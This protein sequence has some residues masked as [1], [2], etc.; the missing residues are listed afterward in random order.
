MSLSSCRWG[1]R[2]ARSGISDRVEIGPIV[3]RSRSG[4]NINTF[5]KNAEV[6]SGVIIVISLI[7]RIY[8]MNNPCPVCNADPNLLVRVEDIGRYVCSRCGAYANAIVDEGLGFRN[9]RDSESAEARNVAGRQHTD[10]QRQIFIT[11]DKRTSA[12][13]TIQAASTEIRRLS[14]RCKI[15]AEYANMALTI[16]NEYKMNKETLLKSRSIVVIAAS[17]LLLAVELVE[18]EERK[19]S[20]KTGRTAYLGM[21]ST[22]ARQRLQKEIQGCGRTGG[23]ISPLDRQLK[24][25][26]E[27]VQPNALQSTCEFIPLLGDQLQL[28]GEQ[29]KALLKLHDHMKYVEARVVPEKY[30]VP[31]YVILLLFL[32]I[33]AADQ[34]GIEFK[35]ITK[36]SV[37]ERKN[38]ALGVLEMDADGLKISEQD[39]LATAYKEIHEAKSKMGIKCE[40][41]VK[42]EH[43]GE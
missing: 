25:I 5:L 37:C 27:K 36:Q 12:Y 18:Q 42:E 9:F 20:E 17:C 6:S 3:N 15:N 39:I 30:T 40:E 19:R 31:E 22:T 7:N 28:S 11:G 29:R 1:G 38:L 4:L 41:G 34:T 2:Y 14:A 33:D 26:K 35:N 10:F 24:D 32:L 13:T 43:K 23:K 21:S 8:S 16:F